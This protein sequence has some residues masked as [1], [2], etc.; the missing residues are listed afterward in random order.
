MM[1]AGCSTGWRARAHEAQFGSVIAMVASALCI[2]ACSAGT[3]PSSTG[4]DGG[5]ASS[6]ADGG[7]GLPVCSWPASLDSVD[8]TSGACRAARRLLSCGLDGGGTHICLGDDPTRC[9]EGSGGSDCH[10]RCKPDE[11]AI[12]CGTIGASTTSPAEPPT[13]CHDMLPTP[14]GIIFYCCSCE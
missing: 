4:Q 1:H 13:G 2:G 3:S 11:Y 8:A 14:G 10:D 9:S 5:G 7:A 6:P 12:V